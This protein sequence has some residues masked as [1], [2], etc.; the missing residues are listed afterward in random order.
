[1]TKGDGPDG[2]SGWRVLAIILPI[3]FALAA[4]TWR[5][6]GRRTDEQVRGS[7]Q[8]WRA[9]SLL[10]SLGSIA[11]FAFGRIRPPDVMTLG[12]ARIHQEFA[13]G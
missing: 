8:L 7:K 3:H 4:L 12:D 10:N 9:A 2:I 13:P 6:I 11:Y 1:V 5:D